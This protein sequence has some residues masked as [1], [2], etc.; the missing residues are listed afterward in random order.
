MG[1]IV[2][3]LRILPP[4]NR[5]ADVLEVLRSVRGPVQ[6]Q[7]GCVDCQILEEEGPDHALVFIERW[8]SDEALTKHLRSES[9]RHILGAIELSGGAPDVRFD[10]VNSTEG[11]ELIARSRDLGAASADDND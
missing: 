3:T 4:P 9:Y 1:M 8:D 6:A 5:R 2:G 7:P 10:H 11:L